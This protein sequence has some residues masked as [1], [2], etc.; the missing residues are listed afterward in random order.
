M[1]EQ[2]LKIPI[3][4]RKNSMFYK[5]KYGASVGGILTSVIYTCILSGINPI[6]YLTMLQENREQVI[7][8]PSAYLPWTY[9]DTLSESI[10][11]WLTDFQSS[12]IAAFSGLPWASKIINSLA[13]ID[14]VLSTDFGH[15]A[16]LPTLNRFWHNQNPLASCTSN[17]TDVRVRLVKANTVP[18][19]GFKSKWFKQTP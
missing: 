15:Q 2:C 17:L 16:S 13:R 1:L 18:L 14:A 19:K 6:E 12:G 3:R 10:A 8:K 7:K 4:H 9:Q 11:A 5:T